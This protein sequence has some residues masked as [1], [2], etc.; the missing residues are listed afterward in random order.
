MS[1]FSKEIGGTGT[2]IYG[3]II[4]EDYNNKLEFPKS[5][6]VF[7]QMRKGDATVR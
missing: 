5:V 6:D 1:I 2:E 7:D 3:G 4:I